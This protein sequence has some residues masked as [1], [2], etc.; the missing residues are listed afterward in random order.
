MDSDAPALYEIQAK[1]EN[2]QLAISLEALS[3]NGLT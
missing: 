2:R 3:A 1:M